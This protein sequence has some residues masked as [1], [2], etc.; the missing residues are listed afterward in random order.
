M[1]DLVHLDTAAFRQSVL[2]Y[3]AALAGVAVVFDALYLITTPG[4]VLLAA[5]YSL[6]ILAGALGGILIAAT[7]SGWTGDLITKACLATLAAGVT[8][9]A[10][11][12]TIGGMLQTGPSDWVRGAATVLLSA[13]TP[14]LVAL[15][16][17]LIT[18]LPYAT[19]AEHN[20][21]RQWLKE[22]DAI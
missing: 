4:R 17:S 3:V 15:T 22:V 10:F 5:A 19:T 7:E 11:V 6:P 21:K 9:T 12:L 13:A 14:V 8:N 20:W 18:S 2:N 16:W 1:K